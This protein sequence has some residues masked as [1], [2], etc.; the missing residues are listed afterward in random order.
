MLGW[1]R[2]IYL[3]L[4][5]GICCTLAVLALFTMASDPSRHLNHN[6]RSLKNMIV[7]A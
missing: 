1:Q 2:G 3:K 7:I 5:S 4:I 6:E